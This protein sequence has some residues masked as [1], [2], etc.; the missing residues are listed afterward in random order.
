VPRAVVVDRDALLL[1]RLSAELAQN[2]FTVETLASMIGLTPDLLELSEPD[3][4]LLDAELPGMDHPALLVIARSLKARRPT[5]IILSTDTDAPA[6]AKRVPADRV[7][8]RSEL[9]S[10]GAVALGL[11]VAGEPRFDLAGLIDRVLSRRGE[12]ASQ[13]ALLVRVDLFSKCNFYVT[14]GK[15]APAGV[16]FATSVLSPIGQRLLV[17]LQLL[18]RPSIR[19]SGE[20]AWVRPHSSFGGRVPT[21]VGLRF[22][23]LPEADRM[24][25]DGFLEVREP[26]VGS[27]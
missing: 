12:E 5:R 4:L 18:G 1:A 6:L 2:G 27:S 7:L 15:S 17:D 11:T 19:F 9:L 10:Q 25:V 22:L 13:E 14:P 24:T 21:G 16:F 23:D 26:L 20:V 8:A 3:L